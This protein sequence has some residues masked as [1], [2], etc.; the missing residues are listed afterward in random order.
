MKKKSVFFTPK[1]FRVLNC[2]LLFFYVCFIFLWF[3]DNIHPLKKINVSCLF[4]LIPLIGI[5]LIKYFFK[6]K[7]KTIKPRLRLNKVFLALSI[8]IFIAVAFRIPF[9]AHSSGMVSSDDAIPALMSK[10][11]ADG[12]LP[13]IYYYGQFYM[14]SLSQHFF[15]LMFAIFGYSIFLLKFSTLLFYLGFITVQFFFIK[16]LF[17]FS[18]SLVIS[19]FYCLPLGRLIYVSFDNTGAYSLVLLLGSVIIYTSYLISHKNRENLI[20][21]LG[22]MMGI[23]F[24][25]HQITACFIL[26]AF[27]ILLFK[28]R[29]QLKRYLRLSFFFLIGSLPLLM[30]EI[31]NKFQLL[32]FL[33]PGG[34]EIKIWEKLKTTTRLSASL[35]SLEI[36]PSKYIF[37]IFLLIGFLTLIYFSLRKKKLQPRSIFSLFFILFYLIYLFSRFSYS[38]VDRYLFP[39]YF[40]IPVLL[41]SVFLFI[42]TRVKYFFVLAFILILFFFYNLKQNY[43]DYLIIKERNFYLNRVIASMEKSGQ[44]YWRGKYWTAYLITALAKEEIIIDSYLFNRYY[45]YRLLYYNQ[46]QSDNFIFLR[47]VGSAERILAMRLVDILKTFKIGFK[48]EEIGDCWLIYEVESPVSPMVLKASVPSQIPYLELTQIISSKGNLNLA[49]KIGKFQQDSGFF[50]VHVEVPG[51]SSGVK[52][53]F[54]DRKEIEVKV[55]FP[56]KKSFKIKYYLDYLGLKIHDT[57]QELSYTLPVNELQKRRKRIVYLSGIGP[58]IKVLGNKR[59]VCEKV[60]KFEINVPS[61]KKTKLHLHLYSPFQF[62][63]PYWYGEYFQIVKIEINDLYIMER[64]LE[65]GENVIELMVEDSYLKEQSNIITLKFKYHFPFGYALLWRTAALLDK[66]EID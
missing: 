55:A 3:K 1:F 20:P 66:I 52:K 32:E 35:I 26:T 34:I 31:Y 60:A 29:L 16:E 48:S 38:A 36:H 45:P 46:S 13:P 47:G 24:W 62:S 21:L 6:I 4:A 7:N 44:R 49:F 41:F 5:I 37:M 56:R 33:L 11:I 10:H 22:F 12:K 28:Y 42:K 8:I 61:R 9:L 30:L 58:Q 23:A 43:S 63:H 18:F 64:R 57:V 54:P 19:L 65:D 59:R 40:C 2:L 51:Y 14:G 39:L 25:A 15:A 53:I 17:S 27:I 50:R